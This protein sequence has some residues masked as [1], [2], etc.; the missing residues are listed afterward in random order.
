MS[1]LCG[2]WS[3]NTIFQHFNRCIFPA[4]L[5][6]NTFWFLGFFLPC[7]S[8]FDLSHPREAFSM[9]VFPPRFAGCGKTPKR[10]G[11]KFCVG[12]RPGRKRQT[13]RF[14]HETRIWEIQWNPFGIFLGRNS[15]RKFLLK[16]MSWVKRPYHWT[17]AWKSAFSGPMK[18][19]LSVIKMSKDC[20]DPNAKPWRKYV[21]VEAEPHLLLLLWQIKGPQWRPSWKRETTAV[22][23]VT[24]IWS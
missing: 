9:G 2:L 22:R 4:S 23:Q 21:C 24:C 6:F 14:R 5:F 20:I 7:F 11:W 16:P 10:A 12:F 17:S 13:F 15:K 1:Q 8:L 3:T 18:L 19:L